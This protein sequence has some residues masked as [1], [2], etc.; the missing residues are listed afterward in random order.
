MATNFRWYFDSIAGVAS[1]AS[2]VA[3]FFAWYQAGKASKAAEAAKTA[4][5]Q[6][7]LSD[8]LE[9]WCKKLEEIVGYL[10]NDQYPEATL[11]AVELTSVL[12]ELP[13]RRDNL[14]S[15]QAK[16]KINNARE[17]LKDLARTARNS[18]IA[19][20]QKRRMIEVI[21]DTSMNL[22]EELGK[23]KKQVD[24]GVKR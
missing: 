21:H 9:S 15:S 20:S 4:V 19:P 2:A 10:K 7:N 11:T 14:L 13:G 17:Q 3:S 24:A 16:D 23:L 8:E 18:P 1:I 22:R 5:F 12:S 6:R